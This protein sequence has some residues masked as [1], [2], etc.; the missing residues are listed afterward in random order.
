MNMNIIAI[1][2]GAT[3]TYV[4]SFQ[5]SI[6][7]PQSLVRFDTPQDKD[8]LLDM[9]AESIQ[10]RGEA[11]VVSMGVP[12]VVIDGKVSSNTNMPWHDWPLASLLEERIGKPVFME[13]DANLAALAEIHA[14]ESIPSVGLYITI[15]TGIGNGIIV[16]GKLVNELSTSEAGLITLET[17]DG[18]KD[19]EH[20]VSGK[21][22]KE[23]YGKNAESLSDS[24]WQE[25]VQ[26]I[27]KGLLTIIPLLRPT[28][29]VFGGSVGIQLE[30][31]KQYL[32]A[33]LDG[34]LPS[35]VSKPQLLKASYDEHSVLYGCREL[36]HS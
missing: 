17:A 18:P 16:N 29:I 32:E 33:Y 22:I 8:L 1:D 20:I 13:N 35:I 19:W 30:Q 27:G 21:A 2:V 28:V 10:S 9:L 15:S 34:N 25:V 36:A 23:H 31:F 14:L 12:G 4:A 6:K 5:N 3:K 24:E 26:D 11:E 7:A